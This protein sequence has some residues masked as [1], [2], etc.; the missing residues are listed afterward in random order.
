MRIGIFCT[1]F[2]TGCWMGPTTEDNFFERYADSQCLI[3]KKCYRAR[4][5][6]EYDGM[7]RCL[8]EVQEDIVE[9]KRTLYAEC[10]FLPDQAEICLDLL[11]G[12]NCGD[13]WEDQNEIEN[14]CG[15][16]VWSCPVSQ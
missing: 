15:K 14:A 6:G 11:N 3:Y 2:F 5:D 4:F 10:S 9:E 8:D 16:E 7:T 13:Y 12:S 1:V